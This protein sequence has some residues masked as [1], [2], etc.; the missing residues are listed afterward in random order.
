MKKWLYAGC[1]E[2]DRPEVYTD[3]MNRLAGVTIFHALAGNLCYP[4]SDGPYVACMSR[5]P[6]IGHT[7][8]A[9]FD[10]T[11][12]SRDREASTIF[13][14]NLYVGPQT[15]MMGVADKFPW[16]LTRIPYLDLSRAERFW[17]TERDRRGDWAV[18][19]AREGDLEDADSETTAA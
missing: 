2:R 3:E 8:L 14:P 9:F 6:G 5:L 17:L 4:L 18:I 19:E 15:I 10:P 13:V 7:S 12:G 16:L 1:Y 11:G